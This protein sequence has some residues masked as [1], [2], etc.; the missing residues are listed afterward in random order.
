M[1]THGRAQVEMLS[2]LETASSAQVSV[3][4]ALMKGFFNKASAKLTV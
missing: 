3:C 1:V 2:G 4:R